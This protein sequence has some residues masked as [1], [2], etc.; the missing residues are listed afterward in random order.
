MKR[1]FQVKSAPGDPL[2]DDKG[3]VWY[4]E[5]KQEAKVIRDKATADTGVPHH[6]ALGPD[7]WR[8]G[9]GA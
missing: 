4:F 8:Y 6:V 5:S 2:Y 7:H 9:W 1:L 3:H